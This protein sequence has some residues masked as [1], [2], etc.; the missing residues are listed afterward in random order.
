[1]RVVCPA[2]KQIAKMYTF[3]PTEFPRGIDLHSTRNDICN[4]K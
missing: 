4:D 1:M 2:L 3:P